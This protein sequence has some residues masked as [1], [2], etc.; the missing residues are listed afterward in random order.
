MTLGMCTSG[1]T[2]VGSLPGLDIALGELEFISSVPLRVLDLGCG[3]CSDLDYVIR[4]RN[5]DRLRQ[6][7]DSRN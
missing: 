2:S 1:S 5:D 6:A 4:W 7:G 3:E